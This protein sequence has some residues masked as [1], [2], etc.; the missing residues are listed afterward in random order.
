MPEERTIVAFCRVRGL[1]S[2][3][4]AQKRGAMIAR[5]F[6]RRGLKM[7]SA[8]ELKSPTSCELSMLVTCDKSVEQ[9]LREKLGRL[10]FNFKH[11]TTPRLKL[12]R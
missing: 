5:D 6:A 10:N 3:R 7:T 2:R 8:V 12:P 9:Q 4:L 1:F 11:V